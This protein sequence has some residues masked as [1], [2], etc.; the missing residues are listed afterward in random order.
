MR[1]Q[2]TGFVNSIPPCVAMKVPLV[3]KA[4]GNHLMNSTSLENLKALSLVSATLDIEYVTSL[5][6]KATGNHLMNSTSL[7]NLKALS[8]V[9]ATLDIEYAIK[10]IISTLVS[11]STLIDGSSYRNLKGLFNSKL[12]R[13]LL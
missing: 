7:E 8:L 6:R 5:V 13:S 2:N 11:D 1:T 9:S 12:R 3:R 4:K 10:K